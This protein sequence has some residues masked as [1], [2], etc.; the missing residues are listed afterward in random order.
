PRRSS[1]LSQRNR[2]SPSS[3]TRYSRARSA[4]CTL[5]NSVT[6]SPGVTNS[7]SVV[8]YS[9]APARRVGAAVAVSVSGAGDTVGTSGNPAAGPGVRVLTGLVGD[10]ISVGAA[11]TGA[12]VGEGDGV[13]VSVGSAV[14]ITGCASPAHAAS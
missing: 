1:D 6:F 9:T 8:K 3:S 13:Q 12:S 7:L 2:R 14:T 11:A 10:G 4:P 5:Q